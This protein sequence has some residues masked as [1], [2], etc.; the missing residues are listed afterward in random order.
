MK[1]EFRNDEY[2]KATGKAPRGTG[3][4]A[5]AASRNPDPMD[6]KFFF[7]TLAEAKAQAKAYYK[8]IA[9]QICETWMVIYIL[10]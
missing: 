6:V 10:P 4:W 1:I 5:F 2:I 9:E 8:K 3:S 7:G